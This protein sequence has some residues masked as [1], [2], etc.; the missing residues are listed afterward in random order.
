MSSVSPAPKTCASMRSRTSA[1]ILVAKPER[2]KIRAALCTPETSRLKEKR[3]SLT[4]NP[5]PATLF[6]LPVWAPAEKFR[7]KRSCR[8]ADFQGHARLPGY[9]DL[10]P[11]SFQTRLL[12]NR[13]RPNGRKSSPESSARWNS[14][15]SIQRRERKPGPRFAVGCRGNTK[16]PAE[17]EPRCLRDLIWPRLRSLKWLF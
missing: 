5:P 11:E 17:K 14:L 12:Q 16:V 7:P 4:I 1:R 2:A 6:F 9:P 15:D 3:N 10:N 8:A 13:G